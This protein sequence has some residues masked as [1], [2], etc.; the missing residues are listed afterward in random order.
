MKCSTNVWDTFSTPFIRHR[1]TAEPRSSPRTLMTM[2]HSLQGR[3]G[4]HPQTTLSF[5]TISYFSHQVSNGAPRWP[6]RSD[7]SKDSFSKLLMCH[8]QLAADFGPAKETCWNW[9]TEENTR[10]RSKCLSHRRLGWKRLPA[11]KTSGGGTVSARREARAVSGW[12]R[13]PLTTSHGRQSLPGVDGYYRHWSF[14]W[15]SSADLCNRR[16][17]WESFSH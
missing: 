7:W 8:L 11:N 1:E 13:P 17:C 12:H 5:H 4:Q 14:C 15:G 9:V 10:V 2:P 6:R 3:E 16:R